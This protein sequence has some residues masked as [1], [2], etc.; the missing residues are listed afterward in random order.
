MQ[1]LLAQKFQ[2]R[3]V[4]SPNKQEIKLQKL[5]DKTLAAQVHINLKQQE[6]IQSQQMSTESP[7][8]KVDLSSIRN[9]K[10]A[11]NQNGTTKNKNSAALMRQ[12]RKKNTM[13]RDNQT[14]ANADE[15]MSINQSA[16][17]MSMAE[18]ENAPAQSVLMRKMMNLNTPKQEDAQSVQV[19][20]QENINT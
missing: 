17:N 18:T 2:V 5:K 16:I 12:L 6:E 4:E 15:S 10:Q 7:A 20:M 9:L 11:L 19:K 13:K 14:E 3:F 1:A 8:K